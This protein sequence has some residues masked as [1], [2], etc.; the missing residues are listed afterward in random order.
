MAFKL[1]SNKMM[2]AAIV[3]AYAIIS[4]IYIVK[5]DQ[6][7]VA[8]AQ[9]YNRYQAWQTYKGWAFIALTSLFLWLT[10]SWAWRRAIGMALTAV[11]VQDRLRLA[12]NA[13]GGAV[14]QADPAPDGRMMVSASGI[15]SE[16]LHLPTN[17][18]FDMDQLR[19]L[20]HP[21]DLG[22]YDQLLNL[23]PQSHEVIPDF[24][25]RFRAPDG[26]YRWVTVVAELVDSNIDRA[27]SVVGV[28]LDVTEAREA[29]QHLEDVIAGGEL[30]TWRFDLRNNKNDI[31]DRWAEIIGYSKAELGPVSLELW[32]SLLHP[33]DRHKMEAEQAENFAKGEYVFINELRLR[34][35]DGHWVWVQS[36][37]RA[38]GFA[39]DGAVEVMTGV[40]VDI[41]VRKSLEQDLQAERDFLAQLTET[42]VSGI[43]ALDEKGRVLFANK[44]AEAILGSS[45]ES[46]LGRRHNNPKWQVSTMDGAN[47]SKPDWPFGRVLRADH[48]IRDMRMTFH[49]PDGVF[50]AVSV[51]GAP[52]RAQGS[53]I[54]VV[55][56][57]TDI[58]AQLESQ[59]HLAHAAEH[60][61]YAALHDHMT[62]LPNRELFQDYL[63]A[64]TRHARQDGGN[65]MVVFIDLDNFKQINDTYGHHAGDQ[66]L[67]DVA[68]RF[69][70]SQGPQDTLARFGGDEFTLLH[71]LPEGETMPQALDRLTRAL[72]RP[73]TLNGGNVYLTASFGVSQFPQDAGDSEEILRN[74]D[75]AMYQAKGNGRNQHVVFSSA[76][77]ERLSRSAQ[78]TQA[79]QRALRNRSFSLVLMP[80]VSLKVPGLVAGAEALLRCHDPDL[81]EI[82]PAEFIP[83]AE[84]AGLIRSI[85]IHVVE[86][87]GQLKQSWRAQGL[88][89]RISVNLSPE[90]L[91][92]DGFGAMM[93]RHLANARLAPQDILIELTESA[94][95]D[96]SSSTKTNMD[97]L[98]AAGFEM[99]A[100][101]FGTGYSSLAYLHELRLQELKID[102]S[103]II[104]LGAE[105]G[106]SDSIVRAILA[107]AQALGLRTVAEGV[108][109]AAPDVL[110]DRARMRSG[111]GLSA[112]PRIAGGRLCR[113]PSSDQG[114]ATCGAVTRHGHAPPILAGAQP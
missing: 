43:I 74:A 81:A 66:L 33:D 53:P 93:V 2:P 109:N 77:R 56:S 11:R 89:L 54:R 16:S 67:R 14:W 7:L 42:S 17:S 69:R 68:Q 5:S 27:G 98:L 83:I 62:G 49:R 45:A 99:A 84:D 78:I 35:R 18:P 102:R 26:S 64:A 80:K 60:A 48:A 12:L 38:V 65:L 107:M 4:S 63:E 72:E 23:E 40:H 19:E 10:L 24:T 79:L 58:T 51:N 104:R 57:V 21:D 47:L 101:D 73:F 30:A 32:N 97:A 20:V 29:A 88:D 15:L 9:D 8:L 76:L 50:R 6:V 44:E 95:M 36:R 25:C 39:P 61:Q 52:I 13:A 92:S 85:D 46:M 100:D 91:R 71:P 111:S 113:T 112:G 114:C 31:N 41:S 96:M 37:G 82:G 59:D 105:D 94:L 22:S 75:L 86:L 103:F 1:I 106:G 34:H 87:L 55:F 3:A 108:D 90:S 28:A 70:A 110:A